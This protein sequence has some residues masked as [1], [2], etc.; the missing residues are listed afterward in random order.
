MQ[1]SKW[2]VIKF[3]GTSVSSKQ[4]WDN[5][6]YVL[7]RRLEEGFHPVV[8]CSALSGVT[9]SLVKLLAAIPDPSYRDH[10]ARVEDKYRA[11]AA[12]LNVDADAL[13]GHFF[14]ELDQL[15]RGAT[16]IG[17]VSPRRRAKV[18]AFAS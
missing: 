12:E 8:V 2:I 3:G 10:L 18:T 5:I 16:M 11:L 6:H 1:H 7:T 15:T 14:A 13:L 9:D 4:R 17:E